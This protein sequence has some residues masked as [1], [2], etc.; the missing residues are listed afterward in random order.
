MS[1]F[2][3]VSLR[4]ALV[5]S[6]ALII[7][8]CTPP[9][10]PELQA[11]LADNSINC[12]SSPVTVSGSPALAPVLD[13]WSYEYQELCPNAGATALA[14]GDPGVANVV[15]SESI[16]APAACE[17][18]LTVPLLVGGVSISTSLLGLD[19]IILDPATLSGIVNGNITSWSDPE[20]VALNPQFDPIELP[21][22][23]GTVISRADAD[24]IDAWLSRVGSD[25]WTGFPDSFTFTETFDEANPP[26]QIYEDGGIVFVPSSF[27]IAY[28]LQSALLKVDPELDAVPS[29]A[30]NIASGVSQLSTA[31]VESPLETVVDPNRKPLP[32]PGFEEALAPWQ[33]LVVS[34]A[35]VCKGES[36][37]DSQAFLRFGL[38]SSSQTSLVNYGF[39]DMPIEV[40][41]AAVDLVSRGLPSPSPIEPDTAA[42]P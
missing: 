6:A 7:S 34:Y 19:G 21:I 31:S 30:E 41:G 42:T 25:S 32:A 13:Q 10:P 23:L 17:A 36:E 3:G 18:S 1:H 35:H 20:I 14:E 9:F 33:A 4:V 37:L 12:G 5:S 28:S 16:A 40:R 39:F 11:Q 38:R 22:Q 8:G 29:F 27:A 24:S 26:S 15:V 2:K